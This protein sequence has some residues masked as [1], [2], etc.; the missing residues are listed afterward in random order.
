MNA[1]LNPF[2]CFTQFSFPHWIFFFCKIFVVQKRRNKVE[3]DFFSTKETLSIL[4]CWRYRI[5][6]MSFIFSKFW[7]L[8]QLIFCLFFLFFWFGFSFVFFLYVCM[9]TNHLWN[10]FLSRTYTIQNMY[11]N[12]ILKKKKTF[13]SFFKHQE[14]FTTIFSINLVS[15]HC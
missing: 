11:K 12:Q 10:F 1:N 7:Q 2:T 6:Y 8:K 5:T 13:F 14:I 9:S 15:S 4:D 3:I